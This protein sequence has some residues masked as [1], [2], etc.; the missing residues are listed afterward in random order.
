M[1]RSVERLACS[2][3]PLA[4]SAEVTIATQELRELRR[5]YQHA[6]NAYMSCVEAFSEA[7]D[8]GV[9]PQQEVVD[10]EERALNDLNYSRQRLLDA[11]FTH[12]RRPA[13]GER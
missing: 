2:K 6:Y 4:N 11:L 1:V 10:R 13:R 7:S 8:H 3:L 12:S 9:W 5:M